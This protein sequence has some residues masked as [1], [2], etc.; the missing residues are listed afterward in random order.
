MSLR[1]GAFSSPTCHLACPPNRR[2]RS[3]SGVDR[4]CL[5]LAST[6]RAGRSLIY[7]ILRSTQNDRAGIIIELVDYYSDDKDVL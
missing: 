5:A 7:E 3:V 1:G 6:R 4:A 2:E